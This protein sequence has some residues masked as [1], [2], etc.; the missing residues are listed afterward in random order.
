M[1]RNVIFALSICAPSPVLAE[2]V[3]DCVDTKATGFYWEKNGTTSPTDFKPERFTVKVT[4]D[5]QRSISDSTGFVITY[6]CQRPGYPPKDRIV[7]HV[8]WG[9]RFCAMRAPVCFQPA[10]PAQ[11]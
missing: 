2:E 5:L 6:M 3:L 11:T 9:F 10:M 1:Y 8:G 4:S 7:L